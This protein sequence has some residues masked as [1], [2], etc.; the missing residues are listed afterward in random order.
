MKIEILYPELCNLYGDRGNIN[1]LR[2][3]LKNAE[4]VETSFKTEPLFVKETPALIYLGPSNE[5]NQE[6]IIEELMPYK[7]RLKELIN[8]GVVM[9]FTG[10]AGEVLFEEIEDW[11]GRKIKGLSVLPFTAKRDRY[12]RFN[13]LNLG[14]FKD[15]FD[16]MGFR[17]QFTMWYGDNSECAFIKCRRGAGIN[18]ESD[19]E[20]I[21]VNNMIA[22]AQLGPILVNNPDLTRWLLDTMGAKDAEVALEDDIRKTYAARLAEFENPK[23]KDIL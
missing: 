10:N 18:R 4:F 7:N 5:K 16:V 14:S 2:M 12:V 15:K 19:K 8:N 21:M 23:T 13:G 17:S 1:Y 22:T 3:C 11:D 9:L 20:G 6:K